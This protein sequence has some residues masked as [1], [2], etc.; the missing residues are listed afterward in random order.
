MAAGS[1]TG[2]IYYHQ[3]NRRWIHFAFLQ[4]WFLLKSKVERVL[5][6]LVIFL[7]CND[8]S[9]IGISMCVN[10]DV[11]ECSSNGERPGNISKIVVAPALLELEEQP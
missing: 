8:K 10:Q 6:Y 7:G 3:I 5:Y 2:T 11:C 9:A 1:I 4:N